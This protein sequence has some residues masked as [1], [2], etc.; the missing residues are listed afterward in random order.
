MSQQ[1]ENEALKTTTLRLQ[2][3]DPTGIQVP[4]RSSGEKKLIIFTSNDSDW[5]LDQDPLALGNVTNILYPDVSH[6]MM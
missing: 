1:M 4:E 5:W 6:I 2:S 3:L